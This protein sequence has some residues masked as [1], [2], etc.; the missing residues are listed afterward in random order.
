MTAAASDAL[1]IVYDLRDAGAWR[2]AHR[3]RRL[4]GHRFTSYYVLDQDHI[5]IVFR[6]GGER[7]EPWERVRLGWILDRERAA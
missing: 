1:T 4:W 2:E 7:W 5:V 6:P 3:H